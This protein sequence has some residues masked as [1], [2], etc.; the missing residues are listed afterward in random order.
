[1]KIEALPMSA[2]VSRMAV[3]T[4]LLGSSS[5]GLPENDCSSSCDHKD[6]NGA[7]AARIAVCTLDS[8]LSIFVGKSLPRI[9]TISLSG[10]GTFRASKAGLGKSLATCLLFG[11][12]MPL[13]KVD[14][15][16]FRIT[17][18]VLCRFPVS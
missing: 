7:G 17:S 3:S 8:S 13:V 18:G 6:N 9:D 2:T 14:S 5:S 11:F 4:T 16:N 12:G 10:L 15:T 1:M